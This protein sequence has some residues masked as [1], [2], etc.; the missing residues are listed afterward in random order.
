MNYIIYTI[1]CLCLVI[2]QTTILPFSPFGNKFYDLLS[3][4][5]I[6]FGLFRPVREGIPVVLVTGFIMDGLSGGPAGLYATTYFWLLI[7]VKFIIQYLHENNRILWPIVVIL[8]VLIENL[9]IY[10]IVSLVSPHYQFNMS[11]IK[12]VS[13]QLVWA[14]LTGPMI[15]MFLYAV[16]RIRAL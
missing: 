6:F 8:G 10:A 15:L 5:V 4:L 13:I 1:S 3:P 2:I 7:A 16:L 14:G 11:D 12:A 9:M